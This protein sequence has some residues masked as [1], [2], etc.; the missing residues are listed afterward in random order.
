MKIEPT[1]E[2]EA[3]NQP[4]PRSIRPIVVGSILGA[5]LGSVLFIALHAV[6]LPA[7]VMA[8]IFGGAEKSTELI[9]LEPFWVVFLIGLGGG[10]LNFAYSYKIAIL[11]LLGYGIFLTSIA[12][13]AK[14][15]SLFG[16]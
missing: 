2:L 11:K 1:K 9:F 8:L 5:L 15:I 13:L 10:I 12:I 4:N 16:N 6:I 14:F 7:I 3:E